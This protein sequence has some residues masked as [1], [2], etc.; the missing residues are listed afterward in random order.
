VRLGHAATHPWHPVMQ[1]HWPLLMCQVHS[2]SHALTLP[3]WP[4]LCADR[5]ALHVAC[6]R[7]MTEV[8][9]LLLLKGAKTTAQD[10]NGATPLLEAA[11]HGRE[12]VMELLINSQVELGWEGDKVAGLLCECVSK[13]DDKVLRWVG[14]VACWPG[15]MLGCWLAGHNRQ[16]WRP[17]GILHEKQLPRVLQQAAGT[18]LACP[19]KLCW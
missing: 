3:A 19:L 17:C 10:I 14:S 11:R 6:A 7:G 16:A 1:Y 12:P 5:S 4:M 18:G 8:V 2:R 15:C 13:R 9:Q